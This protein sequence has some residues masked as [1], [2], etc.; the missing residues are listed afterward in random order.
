MASR[1]VVEHRHRLGI[2]AEGCR[3]MGVADW[4]DQQEPG[5]RQ[6]V[7][8]GTATVA[9][10]LNGLGFSHRRL[11]L[12]PQVFADQPVEQL[13]GPGSM[14][15]D[16]NDAWL[17]RTL[18]WCYG[19]DVTRQFAGLALR[20]RRALGIAVGRAA[21]TAFAVHGQSALDL[22]EGLET[23]ETLKA[24][25]CRAGSSRCS[26]ASTGI[27]PC[28]PAGPVP[29]KCC[30]SPRCIAWCYIRSDRPTKTAI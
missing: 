26:R 19:H 20:A 4:L 6:Q 29:P 9:L 8:V 30:G 17:R 11:D 15:A 7:S 5:N 3:E 23:P 21:T 18:D 1:F 14:A 2:V 13:L 24:A 10:V 12:V 27:T 28:T 22:P 16:R 25:V